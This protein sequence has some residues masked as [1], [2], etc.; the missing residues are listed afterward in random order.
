MAL[1]AAEEH[2]RAVYAPDYDVLFH[3][4]CSDRGLQEQA[5][6]CLLVWTRQ[7]T[8]A[9]DALLTAWEPALARAYRDTIGLQRRAPVLDVQIVDDTDVEGRVGA[10]RQERQT[11]RL[12]VHWMWATNQVV[13]ILYDRS[14]G[15]SPSPGAKRRIRYGNLAASAF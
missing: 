9:L 10:G 12:A 13:D 11:T 15:A 2:V 7:R 14:A 3:D 8:A 1:G 6:V 5:L 4:L